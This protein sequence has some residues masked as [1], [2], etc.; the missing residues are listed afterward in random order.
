[1]L[2]EYSTWLYFGMTH[3]QEPRYAS[4]LPLGIWM[5]NEMQAGIIRFGEEM[6]RDIH[7][8][9]VTKLRALDHQSWIS[10][11]IAFAA[12]EML[13]PK[14]NSFPYP[15]INVS[16][17]LDEVPYPSVRNHAFELGYR[18][19]RHLLTC[20]ASGISYLSFSN[21]RHGF[22]IQREQGALQ[23]CEEAGKVFQ[24]HILKMKMEWDLEKRHA[25]HRQTCLDWLKEQQIPLSIVTEGPLEAASLEAALKLTPWELGRDVS[26]IQLTDPREQFRARKSG[27][28][29][30]GQDWRQVGYVAARSLYRWVEEGIPPPREV[31]IPP[32]APVLTSSS[33]ASHISDLTTR[34]RS[35]LIHSQDFGLQ[36]SDVAESLGVSDSSL[37]KE[38]KSVT[39][40][41]PKQHL[42][43]R[44]LEEA[45][46]LLRGSQLSV[47]AVAQACGFRVVHS[48]NAA[49]RRTEGMPPGQWRLQQADTHPDGHI[50]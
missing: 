38:I 16:G 29:Y 23:A 8:F 21:H 11:L 19:A 4:A 48:L 33:D 34:F 14:L 7:G 42:S 15:V 13:L 5:G 1:L 2:E 31:W 50:Q 46:R 44:Q 10:G 41:T 47:N 25:Q 12:R 28:S 27:I 36:V 3:V 6:D 35:A 26:L 39:G 18:A 20:G 30:I 32:L 40:K 43:E 49:F 22:R 24:I 17:A 9:R 37:L 45:K